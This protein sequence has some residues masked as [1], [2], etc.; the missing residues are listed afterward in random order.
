MFSDRN[1]LPNRNYKDKK[2]LCPMSIEY[3]KIHTYYNDYDCILYIKD[4]ELL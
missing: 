1:T 4:F 3:K 2:I